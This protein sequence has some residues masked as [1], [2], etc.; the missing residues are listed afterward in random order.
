MWVCKQ[1]P[2]TEPNKHHLH[3]PYKHKNLVKA[4]TLQGCLKVVKSKISLIGH[5]KCIFSIQNSWMNFSL[6]LEINVHSAFCPNA[7]QFPIF[8]PVRFIFSF[9]LL[10]ER[11]KQ[12]SVQNVSSLKK[13]RDVNGLRNVTM[14]LCKNISLSSQLLNSIVAVHLPCWQHTTSQIK[15]KPLPR[16][17]RPG[18]FDNIKWTFIMQQHPTEP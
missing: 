2:R 11:T 14:P 6:L 16:P 7:W 18:G 17:P 9:N 15:T 5:F 1:P 4:V 8:C 3:F 12:L 13:T 10:H